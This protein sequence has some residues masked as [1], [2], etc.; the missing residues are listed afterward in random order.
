MPNIT[1][2]NRAWNGAG[3]GTPIQNAGAPT[4]GTS[5]TRANQNAGKGAQLIDS[6]NGKIYVNTGTAASPTWTVTGSQS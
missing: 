5:G 3:Y 1:K 4:N 2:G 6:T